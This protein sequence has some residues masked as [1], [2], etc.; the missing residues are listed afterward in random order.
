MAV[1]CVMCKVARIKLPLF[2]REE[3]FLLPLFSITCRTYYFLT[4]LRWLVLSVL[5]HGRKCQLRMSHMTCLNDGDEDKRFMG[6]YHPPPPHPH[7]QHCHS[8]SYVQRSYYK[9]LHCYCSIP[10]FVSVILP[11]FL[12]VNCK[13]AQPIGP[14]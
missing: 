7:P 5:A 9:Y 6:H 13:K 1:I 14:P 3:Q 10:E 8:Q 2:G 12:W 11:N 4:T